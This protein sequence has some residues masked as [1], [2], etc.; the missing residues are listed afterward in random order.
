MS[1]TTGVCRFCYLW[2]SPFLFVCC[3]PFL[4]LSAYMDPSLWLLLGMVSFWICKLCFMAL[5]IYFCYSDVWYVEELIVL[6]S[7]RLLKVVFFWCDTSHFIFKTVFNKIFE[8]GLSISPRKLCIIVTCRCKYNFS[9][10]V[11]TML[12]LEVSWKNTP[13]VYI[14]CTAM[15]YYS[16]C[17]GL[18]HFSTSDYTVQIIASHLGLVVSWKLCQLSQCP[19]ESI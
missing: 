9:L 13:T 14:I 10:F 4:W 1:A 3:W 8:N 7:S 11:G 18:C 15:L 19:L 16:P 6:T 12:G 2:F 5:V 17:L